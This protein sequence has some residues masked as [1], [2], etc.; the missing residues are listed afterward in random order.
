MLEKPASDDGFLRW[1]RLKLT[2]A[3]Y[4]SEVVLRTTLH[5][6]RAG[7]ATQAFIDR[8]P[9]HVIQRQGRWRSD[10][11]FIYIRL[12]MRGVHEWLARA[13]RQSA[14]GRAE[15]EPESAAAKL[16]RIQTECAA[17]DRAARDCQAAAEATG[18]ARRWRRPQSDSGTDDDQYN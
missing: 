13:L 6:L 5:S 9:V 15:R 8:V 1:I 12:S 17:A 2:A 10:A 14:T 7:A 16:R 3:G 4:P 18:S 11:V